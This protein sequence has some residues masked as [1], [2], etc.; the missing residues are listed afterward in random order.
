[1]NIKIV[2]QEE[3]PQEPQVMQTQQTP[4]IEGDL[5]IQSVGQIFNMR[6]QEIQAS[7]ERLNLLIDYAKTQTDDHTTEGL[8]WAIRALQGRVGTPPLGEKWLSYLGKYAYIKL[9][10]LKMQKEVEKYEHNN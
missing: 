7:K 8:K 10:S 4:Y 6:P 1:M 2:G 5:L 9:E 3:T